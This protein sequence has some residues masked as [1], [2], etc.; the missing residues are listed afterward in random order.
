MRRT[1]RRG[2]IKDLGLGIG[3]LSAGAAPESVS[4][5]TGDGAQRPEKQRLPQPNSERGPLYNINLQTAIGLGDE[6]ASVVD[7][8]GQ[9]KSRHARL[10][11][12]IGQPLK[13][14]TEFKGEQRLEE[15]YLPIVYTTVRLPAGAM[16]SVA[17]ASDF[18]GVKADYWAFDLSQPCRVTLRFPSALWVTA[19]NGVAVSG[20]QVLAA[21]PTAAQARTTQAKFNCPSL[22]DNVIDIL[23]ESE[24]SHL[25]HLDP[26]FQ[27]SR[28]AASFIGS[29]KIE[30]RFPVTSDQTYY[31]YLGVINSAK[32]QPGEV[33]LDFY[34]E[35]HKQTVDVGL[36]KL[37]RPILSEFVTRAQG[38][39]ISV[40]VE[41]SPSATNPYRPLFINGIWIF[42]ASRDPTRIVT[43]ECNSQALFY[44][45]C[46]R[47]PV[48]DLASSVVLDFAPREGSQEKAWLRFPYELQLTDA[49]R[50]Q[51]I[52]TNQAIE[53]AK[54]HWQTLLG[55][56]ASF[57]T[58][59]PKLDNLYKTS[60]INVFL[61]RTGHR[62]N[63]ASGEDLYIVKPGCTIYDGF[64]YRDGGYIVNALDRAGYPEEAEKSLRLFWMPDLEGRMRT[65]G[66]EPGGAWS[67]PLTEW[68]GQGQALWA[69]VHHYEIT[70]NKAWL[71]R[72]YP[73]VRRGARWIQEAT[74]QTTV[75]A[76]DGVKPI[77]YGLLPVGEGEAIGHGYIYYH[78]FWAVLGLRKAV[79][80]AA[81]LGED[82][83]H[84][85]MRNC[86][87]EFTTN[88][89]RSVEQA[90]R[91]SGKNSFIPG[92]P[93]NP[94][95]RIWGTLAALYPCEFLEPHDPMLTSTLERMER[96]SREGLYVFVG[97]PTKDTKMWTYI[98]TDW[99][100]CYLARNELSKFHEHFDGYVD[101]ASPTNA[102][103]EEIW[104]DSHVG[105]GDMPHGWAAADYVLLLRQ[106][107]V[108]ETGNKLHLCWGIKADWL[109]GEREIQV[110]RAPTAFGN[111]SFSLKRSSATSLVFHHT[112]RTHVNQARPEEVILHIPPQVGQTL[113]SIE[114]NQTPHAWSA[115]Q[116]TITI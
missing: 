13:A 44:V 68:D 35:E 111:L 11:C 90:Y 88:L 36:G 81:A 40:R 31:V 14:V 27:G 82:Q 16:S 26:A 30:Y 75:V 60:L 5:S 1:G 22:N 28:H 64:W 62:S 86:Y 8:F 93:Y 29:G 43:G 15:G 105:T 100:M 45:P 70:G 95:A 55:K 106:A 115:E 84:S 79:V 39:R 12:E 108:W 49:G 24:A 18:G 77:Y 38:G 52:S 19:N 59:V 98:T 3:I 17:F 69:L 34:V 47:E 53:T 4:A 76:E 71:R 21:W 65:L 112:L 56:G 37:G 73:A 2:F 20:N 91:E 107:L 51:A 61:L 57:A 46:G 41:C 78:N 116:T 7:A 101:H 54:Q 89:R 97:E 113:R 42:T 94:G 66:Q 58:G 87:D 99:A 104:I 33:I 114:I 63:S 48:R 74:A 103:I 102:W 23:P 83:D 50:L 25:R 6:R 85:W 110:A 92:D 109:S 9:L 96:H 32:L 67:R 80:A 10:E 72:V